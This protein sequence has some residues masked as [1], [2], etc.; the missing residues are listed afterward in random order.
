MLIGDIFDR[1]YWLSIIEK[2]RATDKLKSKQAG[3]NFKCYTVNQYTE[4]G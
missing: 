1:F 3:S 4:S 2:V